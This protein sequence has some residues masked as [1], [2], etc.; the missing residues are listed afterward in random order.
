M[1][2]TGCVLGGECPDCE[3]KRMTLESVGWKRAVQGVAGLNESVWE[4]PKFPGTKHAE[5]V[6]L[7]LQEGRDIEEMERKIRE[8]QK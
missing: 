1:Y 8:E 4:D 3:R 5:S 7:K 6:A 2:I